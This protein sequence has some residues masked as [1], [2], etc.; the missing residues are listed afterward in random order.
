MADQLLVN[1]IRVPAAGL[2]APGAI[3]TLPHGLKSG[4]N[5]VQ[6]NQYLPWQATNIIVNFATDTDVTFQNTDP[7]PAFAFFRVEYDHS[8]HAVGAGPL[9]WRGVSATTVA[10]AAAVYG[11]F[12]SNLDQP[13]ADGATGIS[14]ITMESGSGV[15][16]SVVDPGTGPSRITVAAAGVYSFCISPQ[17]F[18]SAGA[19]SGQI[20]FWARKNGTDIPETTSFV[21]ITNNQHILPFVEII[22]TMAAGQYIEWV[23]HADKINCTLEQEPASIAPAIVRPAAPSV[24]CT[25]KRLGS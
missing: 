22:E 25:V 21:D 9:Y 7:S 10:G 14:T 13:I 18:K 16:V 3:V 15:G 12:Y 5:G 11:Q 8:I 20:S 1:I 4:G 23:A 2:L 6:P 19:G 24:I 17:F